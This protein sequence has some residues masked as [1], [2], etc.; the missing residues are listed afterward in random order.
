MAGETSP[1]PETCD[2][3]VV[4]AGL[5]GAAAAIGL[6]R[7]GFST[8]SCGPIDRMGQGRTVA[9]FGRSIELLREFGVWEE[10][11]AAAAPLRSLRIVDDTGSLFSARPVEFHA[12]EIELDA[13]GWNI[14]NAAL[15]DLLARPLDAC[16]GLAR[17]RAEVER[18]DFAP[19]AA[20]LTTS[21]GRRYSAR[22]VVGADGR[23]SAA[24]KAAGIDATLHRYGQS[25]LTL[26]LDHTRPHDDFSTEFHTREGPFTLVP[27]PPTDKAANRSSL[28]WVMSEKQG[29]R[30]VALKEAD[31]IGEINSQSRGLLGSIALEG[32][33]GLF[34]MVRQTVRPLTATRLA[35]VG[36]AAH[37]FPPIGA[38][39]LN[40]GLRDVD[41]IVKAARAARES[42]RDIGAA[43][44]L[45]DYARARGPDI[46][47]RMLAVNGLNLSLLADIPAVDALRG[48]GLTALRH[49]GPL[50][51]LVMREGVSPMLAR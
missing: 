16:P 15:A 11:E 34:P 2:A 32:A 8:V 40:L 7:A 28:V 23:G 3:F 5:A 49:F 6:A 22:L 31:L 48:M 25:A 14:E 50:R 26:F 30:R 35:L 45:A 20:E 46:S 10:V 33:R 4:G 21:D 27:L 43:A 51:R 44:T 19:D 41:E 1:K 42:G 9:L 18:F 47:A 24:R 38:Q 37:A 36:D 39:G 29:R 13:F 12:S 17:T